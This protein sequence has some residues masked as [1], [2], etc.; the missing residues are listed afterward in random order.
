MPESKYESI[1]RN[2]WFV[3][4]GG[5]FVR[6]IIIEATGHPI[7]DYSYWKVTGM[8]NSRRQGVTNRLP[9]EMT[10]AATCMYFPDL[11]HSIR[12]CMH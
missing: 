3:K 2:V 6:D 10:D 4:C 7:E 5:R 8:Q 1:L 9:R 12:L 11:V